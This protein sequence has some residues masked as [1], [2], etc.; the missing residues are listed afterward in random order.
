MCRWECSILAL[1][2]W[3]CG[4]MKHTMLKSVTKDVLCKNSQKPG[5]SKERSR[6]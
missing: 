1:N 2:L 5:S 6:H 4:I 3:D